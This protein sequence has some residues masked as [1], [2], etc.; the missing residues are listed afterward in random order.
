MLNQLYI[1]FK[2]WYV[3]WVFINYLYPPLPDYS[4]ALAMC[5]SIFSSIIEFSIAMWIEHP[6]VWPRLWWQEAENFSDL[7]LHQS[8]API[9]F[10]CFPNC[11]VISL[12]RSPFLIKLVF[13]ESA[14]WADSIIESRCPSVCPF[15]CTRFWGLF[16]PHFPKSD[17][18]N[19]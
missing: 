10:C 5:Y 18:Q 2:T 17:V 3:W 11:S 14:H 16:C 13:I 6:E 19:F 4:R 8:G 9:Q 12:P 7:L 1:C 15:S